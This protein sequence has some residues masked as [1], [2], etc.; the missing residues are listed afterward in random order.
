MTAVFQGAAPL[1]LAASGLAGA[2]PAGSGACSTAVLADR[3]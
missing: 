3:A 2:L 1:I